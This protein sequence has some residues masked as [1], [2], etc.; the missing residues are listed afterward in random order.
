MES[1]STNMRDPAVLD[2]LL[3]STVPS[4]RYL[5]RLYLD[6]DDPGLTRE[7]MRTGPVPVILAGQTEAGNWAGEQSYYT[8]KYV[9]THWSM[10]LATE[11]AA[12]GSD[13]RLQ[14]GVEFMLS[15]T[16]EELQQESARGRYGLSCFWG[17]LLRYAAYCG[18]HND[19]RVQAITHYLVQDSLGSGWRCRYND[20]LACAWGCARALWGLAALPAMERMPKVRETIDQGVDWLLNGHDLVAADYPTPGRVHPLWFR[21]NF[22][23]FYQADIL[24]VLRVLTELGAGGHP[25][26]A[27]ALEWLA[28]RR[29]K[30]GRWRGANPFRL[31][32]WAGTADG[33]DA[34]R[35]ATLY[36]LRV[37]SPGG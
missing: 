37:L 9:S 22:P 17:N 35:W 30:N 21:L 19:T 3:A 18:F 34:D 2:W 26:A 6:Q 4:I 10:L 27:A 20:G 23:L 29:M 14:A 32:T 7:I 33:P 8:P 13:P 25:G 1:K 28:G 5:T 16:R 36:A 11:L 12:D 15:A 31:R 24:F